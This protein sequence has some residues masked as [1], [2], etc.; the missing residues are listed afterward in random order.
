MARLFVLFLLLW[1]ESR[2]NGQET[3][4][5]FLNDLVAA[6]KFTSPT[7]LYD[8]DDQIPEI[9]FASHWVLCL[10]SNHDGSDLKELPDYPDGDR[11][12]KNV[13]MHI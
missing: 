6:F 9:C 11:D 3:M 4:D 12:S 13:G 1:K 5:I 10:S 8:S 7:I 2:V